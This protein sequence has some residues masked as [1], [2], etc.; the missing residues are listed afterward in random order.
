MGA[1]TA[2]SA[3]IAAPLISRR[4][5]MSALRLRLSPRVVATMILITLFALLQGL[6]QTTPGS[7]MPL[8]GSA[9]TGLHVV[10][11]QLVD[12]ANRP[13]VLHGGNRSGSE[14]TCIPGWA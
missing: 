4:F 3:C 12:G 1:A 5:A 11:Q 6:F 14:Y 10:G 13:I 8:V 2:L 7:A 9:P